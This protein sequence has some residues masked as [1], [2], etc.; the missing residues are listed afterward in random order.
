MCSPTILQEMTSVLESLLDSNQVFDLLQVRDLVRIGVGP[1]IDVSFL[2][3]KH[4][5]LTWLERNLHRWDY[6][7]IATSEGHWKM[8]PRKVVAP[9]IRQPWWKRMFSSR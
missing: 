7:M 2:E 9:R 5:S 6:C 3:I 4:E 1:S 8:L